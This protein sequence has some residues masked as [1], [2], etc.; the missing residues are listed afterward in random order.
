MCLRNKD[1]NRVARDGRFVHESRTTGLGT[2]GNDLLRPMPASI[3]RRDATYRAMLE[4]LTLG[5]RERETLLARGLNERQIEVLGYRSTA[6]VAGELAS[7][8]YELSRV[9][10]FFQEDGRW[11]SNC[12]E[13]FFVPMRDAQG[14]IAGLQIR[15]YDPKVRYK[16]FSSYMRVLPDGSKELLPY[17]A[18]SGCPVSHHRGSGTTVWITEGSIKS[19]IL[20]LVSGYPVL[21]KA[22]TDAG[23]EDVATACLNF[24]STVLAF[25]QDWRTN[26]FVKNAMIRQAEVIKH[27]SGIKVSVALWDESFN[28]IDDFL[29]KS[30]STKLVV[31]RWEDAICT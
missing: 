10:G 17:G 11:V 22:G 21:G 1:S 23:L 12:R 20:A 4:R 3:Q 25:D 9:P 8:G 24:D 31:A 6:D 7:F 5:D 15:T 26:K 18:S 19:D 30:G 29:L 16:W 28:G 27:R 14:R 2:P 13:G